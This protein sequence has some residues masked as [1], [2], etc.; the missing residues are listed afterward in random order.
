MQILGFEFE[1]PP[2]YR[3]EGP[4]SSGERSHVVL[5]GP[6]ARTLAGAL[7]DRAVA[8]GFRRP[9]PEADPVVLERGE[10]TLVLVHDSGNLIVHMHDP[11]MLP[12]ARFD[13]SA[14][15]LGE[16]QFE[17]GTTSIVPL[18]E[19][20]VPS[21]HMRSGAWT[22]AGVSASQLVERV[23]D[24]VVTTKGLKRGSVFGPAKGGREVW[25]GEAYSTLELLKV[26]AA[27]DAGS[28]L[29]EIDLIDRRKEAEQ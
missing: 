11:T 1:V 23:I 3:V 22:L 26:R 6:N 13:G 17:C 9:K 14:V 10:Q 20:H 16:L 19:R 4:S 15:L 28:V 21:Q 18:R 29:L 2:E 5:V 12:R 27:V 8:A 24:T 7:V 25:S